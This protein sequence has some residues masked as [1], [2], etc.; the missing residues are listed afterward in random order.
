METITIN[1]LDVAGYTDEERIR[2]ATALFVCEN[3]RIPQR[4]EVSKKVWTTC[5]QIAE[6][7]TKTI[8]VRFIGDGTVEMI[9]GVYGKELSVVCDMTLADNV[10]R[11]S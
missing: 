6:H 3:K 7:R 5:W 4:V 9:F 2:H 11:F 1:P 8:T 10:M